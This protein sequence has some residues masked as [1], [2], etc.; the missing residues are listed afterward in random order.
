MP[1]A[2]VRANAPAL[3]SDRR[4]FLRGALTI[5]ALAVTAIPA[6]ADAEEPDPVFAQIERHRRAAARFEE[7]VG[8]MDKPDDQIS[9]ADQAEFD[10]VSE[11]EESAMAEFLDP[12]P[13]T[14]AGL[15][16]AIQYLAEPDVGMRLGLQQD[17]ENPF[18]AL[19]RSPVLAGAESDGRRA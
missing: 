6:L 11:E 10:R 1:N 17:F 18:V 12:P 13:T 7:A 9:P 19:A 8:L 15:I 3:P 4:A 2:T 14:P 16:A 5:G